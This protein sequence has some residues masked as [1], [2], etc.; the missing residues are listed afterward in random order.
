MPGL[1]MKEKRSHLHNKQGDLVGIK[2]ET[3]KETFVIPVRDVRVNRVKAEAAIK[4]NNINT[5][6]KFLRPSYSLMGYRY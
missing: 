4:A 3:E 6:S 1:N 2:V 5:G